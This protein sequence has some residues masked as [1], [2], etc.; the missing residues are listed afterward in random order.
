M[1]FV[2]M[3]RHNLA[4]YS[5]Y[6]QIKTTEISRKCPATSNTNI[7]KLTVTRKE[8]EQNSFERNFLFSPVFKLS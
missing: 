5:S 2:A 6:V 8:I 3:P 7:L 1:I 4:V